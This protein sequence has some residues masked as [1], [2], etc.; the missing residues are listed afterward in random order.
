MVVIVLSVLGTGLLLYS[1]AEWSAMHR[2]NRA[3]GDMSIVLVALAM[4]I[5]PVS[6]LWRG[7][8]RF[9]PYRRELGIYAI[10]LALAH[11]AIILFGWVT[12][13]LMR[14]FG[15]E[16]HPGLQ[17][18]VM[19]N[20]GFALANLIGLLALLYGIILAV[21]SN[22]YSQ[23]RLG[24]NVWKFI[25]QGTYILWWLTVL[26]TAYFL[27]LHF[28]DYH[29]QTPDP[30][31]AQWPFVALVASVVALQFAASTATWRKSRLKRTGMAKAE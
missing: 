10:L 3:V 16:F 5:G 31:W 17:R 12:L 9:L 6:R 29:R 15:F 24:N 1:R 27:F 8:V 7:S 22:D 4:A 20:H 30:N 13:D 25:Q 19:V 14:L 26:H 28:L 18:Y 21:T 23:R 11:A 2:W